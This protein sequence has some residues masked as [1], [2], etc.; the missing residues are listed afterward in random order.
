MPMYFA[1]KKYMSLLGDPLRYLACLG[2]Q[3]NCDPST[4]RPMIGSKVAPSSAC[5]PFACS[6]ISSGTLLRCLPANGAH[7]DRQWS[8]RNVIERPAAIR[9]KE[10]C[11]GEGGI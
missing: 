7:K 5:S 9:T 2:A 11:L 10:N 6:G 4:A 1:T 8:R 3:T